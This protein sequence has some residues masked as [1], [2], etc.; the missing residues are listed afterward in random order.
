MRGQE[1]VLKS[2][3]NNIFIIMIVAFSLKIFDV[4]AHRN[5]LQ[6]IVIFWLSL[7]L[8]FSTLNILY[9]WMIDDFSAKLQQM[10]INW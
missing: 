1:N 6:L 4:V 3:I 2:L 7:S 5:F 8:L 10:I 9:E